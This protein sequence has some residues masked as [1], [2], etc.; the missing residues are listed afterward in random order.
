[1]VKKLLSAYWVHWYCLLFSGSLLSLD[2]G[3][4]AWFKQLPWMVWGT[5][6]GQS[7]AQMSIPAAGAVWLLLFWTLIALGFLG[8]LVAAANL[9]VM[10]FESPPAHRT[11]AHPTEEIPRETNASAVHLATPA[12]I[13]ATADPEKTQAAASSE[14]IATLVN[15]PAI[16]HLMRQL[17]SRFG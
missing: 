4:T 9:V 7:Y 16:S 14:E 10:G 5:D 2:A 8:I 17:N 15:D 6:L 12:A 11:M 1:M 3:P 13:K